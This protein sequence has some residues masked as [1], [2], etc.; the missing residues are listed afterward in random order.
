MEAESSTAA[1]HQPDGGPSIFD[2]DLD[3]LNRL[4]QMDSSHHKSGQAAGRGLP[5]KLSNGGSV[6]D[7]AS[8]HVSPFTWTR[9]AADCKSFG[10]ELPI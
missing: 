10:H 2:P 8:K 1:I 5:Q 6:W 3:A 4:V 9:V 7:D